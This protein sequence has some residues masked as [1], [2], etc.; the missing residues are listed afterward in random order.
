V[1]TAGSAIREDHV[2]FSEPYRSQSVASEH[3]SPRSFDSPGTQIL[4]CRTRSG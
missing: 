1:A 3:P 4:E 2:D